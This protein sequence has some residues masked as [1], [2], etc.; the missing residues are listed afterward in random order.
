MSSRQDVPRAAAQRLSL[1]LRQLQ[2]YQRAG[3]STVSSHE[4][5]G[6]LRLTDA[7]V[8]RDLAYFGQ[9]GLPGVG[10]KVDRL[11]ASLRRILGTDRGWSTAIVGVGNLGSAL[12]RYRGFEEQGFRVAALFDSDPRRV[13]QVAG[14]MAIRPMGELA[15]TVRREA[16]RLGIITVPAEHAQEVADRLVAAG[17]R[18]ILNFAPA[19]VAVPASVALCSVDLALQLEQLSFLVL[20]AQRER[21]RGGT[22]PGV[23]PE[24][25]G[26]GRETEAD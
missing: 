13:G 11:I 21:R 18:G 10:Y 6:G 5:A 17:V 7:Q 14:G 3:R 12:A 4:L 26:D 24:V 15:E 8:R 23:P 20:D 16:V 22:S 9:F 1:Y 19:S 25:S 2:G